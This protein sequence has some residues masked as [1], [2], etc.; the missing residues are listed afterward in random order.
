M[1][2]ATF[3]FYAELGDFLPPARR[4][5]AFEHPF[6]GSP[7]VKDAIEALGVPHTEVDLVLADGEPVGFDWRLAD[8]ARVAVYPVFESF[9]VAG[10]SRVRVEPLRDVRFVLD[11]H[12]GTLARYLRMAGLDA[13]W[14]PDPADAALA[15]SAA[16]ER[17]ILLTRDRGLLKRGEVTHGYAVRSTEPRAQLAEVIRRFDLA[18]RVAPFSRCLRCNA[19]LLAA[20]AAE[21]APEVPPRVRQ[22]A[23]AYRRCPRCRRVYWAGTHH[24]AMERIL[25]DAVAAAA[26]GP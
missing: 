23:Q 17:R 12:L 13:A 20:D 5:V 18:R 14:E 3:R 4:G 24:E 2:R 22:R 6:D 11:G 15:R 9:D 16:A 21:V 1:K 7:A 10:V 8:G 19:G 26:R 25:A